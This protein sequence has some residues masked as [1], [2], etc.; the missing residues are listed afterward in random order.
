MPKN[1]ISER[2]NILHGVI[3]PHITLG[4][5]LLGKSQTTEPCTSMFR[6]ESNSWSA[7]RW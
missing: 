2:Q 4:C 5:P 3:Q 6:V 1:R 7:H